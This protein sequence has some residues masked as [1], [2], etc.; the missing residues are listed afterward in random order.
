L[1]QAVK[2]EKNVNNR[3][4]TITNAEGKKN[5]HHLLHLRFP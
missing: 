3:Q 4:Y 1:K 5:P 2:G